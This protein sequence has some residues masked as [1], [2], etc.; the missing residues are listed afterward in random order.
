M[1]PR[2]LAVSRNELRQYRASFVDEAVVLLV[3]LTGFLML[4]TPAVRDFSLPSSYKLYS[5]GY[6]EGSLVG[7][8]DPYSVEMVPYGDGV[9]MIYA[10]SVGEV[11]GF[12]DRARGGYAVFGSGNRRSDAALSSMGGALADYNSELISEAAAGDPVLSGVLLPVR[13]QVAEEEIDYQMAVSASSELRRRRLTGSGGIVGAESASG[14]SLGGASGGGAAAS[15]AGSSV[16][17]EAAAVSGGGVSLTL[18]GQLDVEFPFAN[19]YRNMTLLS[20]MILLAILLSLSLAREKVDRNIENLFAAPLTGTEILAGKAL[21]YALAMLALSLAY[22]LETSPGFRGL[23]AASV[24]AVISSTLLS[25]SMFSA[26]V[27]RSYRELTFLGSFSIFT[28]FFFIILPNVFAGVSVLAFISPLDTVTSIGNG[29]NVPARDLALSLLPYASL[30]AFFAAFTACTFNP[31]SMHASTGVG[32][33]A[34]MFYGGLSRRLHAGAS[35]AAVS[36]ALLV[37]FVFVVESILAYLVLPL[38]SV[39]PMASLLLLAVVEEAVKILPFLYRRMNPLLYG[40]SAGAAF[41]LTEKA[42][43]LYL[44]AKVY[45]YLGGPYML[46]LGKMLPTLAVHMA[47]TTV[48]ALAVHYGRRR[49]WGIIGFFAAVSIHMAYNIMVLGGMV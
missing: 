37:P 28:F 25:F 6:V 43:N 32:Q 15:Q 12:V 36:V 4:V 27:A 8:L 34:R 9:A 20:P 13:L 5:I 7:G 35:Y 22:G 31:E 16:R 10:S 19:L 42:F 46:F 40:A 23:E 17:D 49:A 45:S 29:G 26:V 24:F 33:L 3:V 48:L 21:P 30:T 1:L 18:P 41:F 38:G 47:A 39:A 44:I 11:D 2:F 14:T